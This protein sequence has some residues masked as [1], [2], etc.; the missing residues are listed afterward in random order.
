[1]KKTIVITGASS[2]IGRAAAAQLKDRGHDVILVGRHPEKT[3]EAAALLSAPYCVADFSKLSE[4]KRLAEELLRFGRI[5]VLC[6]NAGGAQNKRTVTEDGNELTFQVNVLGGFLLTHLLLPRLSE[7]QATVIH[8][9]SIAA[10]LFSDYHGD[11]QSEKDYDP[12]TAYGNA[13]L[14]NILITR[15][16]HRRFGDK[17]AATAFEPG[18]VRTNFASESTPFL[19]FMYHSPL[20]YVFTIS[21]E[22]SARRMV[23]LAEGVPGKD[24]VSGG[25]YSDGTPMKCRFADPSGDHARD[26]WD[27]CE[28]LCRAFW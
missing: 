26:L 22:K 11:L 5:D 20:K 28:A 23:R 1:M 6:N 19:K 7:C 10:N 24:F 17:I 9:T 25:I 2:G 13:K 8:T 27:A 21:P 3:K 15:E 12:M 18:I 16:L 14:E 4:V